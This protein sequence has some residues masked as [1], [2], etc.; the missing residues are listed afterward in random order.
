MYSDYRLDT[1]PPDSR[2]RR[3]WSPDPYDPYPTVRRT[4]NREPS[5]VSVEALDLADYAHTL[6]R[7]QPQPQFRANDPYPSSPRPIR[8]FSREAPSL[9][10]PGGTASTAS[11]SRSPARR[12][13]SLPAS[14][15]GYLPRIA[16]D[17]QYQETEVDIGNFPAF[18]RHWYKGNKPLT[19][20]P[21]TAY[22]AVPH[23]EQLSPFDPAFPTHRYNSYDKL[24]FSEPG[25]SSS[26]DSHTRNVLPWDTEAQQVPVDGEMKQER[27]RMLER[28]FAG[29]GK[30]GSNPEEETLVGS[31]DQRGRLITEGPRKRLATRC[32][33]AIVTL[34]AAISIIYASV[35][36]LLLI[37]VLR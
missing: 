31:V 3:P 12:P 7:P 5:D 6:H 37:P 14:T 34:G 23:E 9:M 26:H 8:S 10:S 29:I 4:G 15:H 24:P 36:R 22:N 35:V 1:P 19:Q 33:Q 13:Y 21:P 11:S 30:P 2:F 17:D 20:S 16:Q 18:S 32:F 28:E 27:M 25:P